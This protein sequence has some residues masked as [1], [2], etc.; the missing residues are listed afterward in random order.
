MEE[1]QPGQQT[2]SLT[3][4]STH[5]HKHSACRIVIL[6]QIVG[7]K[8]NDETKLTA[9]DCQGIH[10][11]LCCPFWPVCQPSGPEYPEGMNAESML[12]D[13]S[14]RWFSRC[15]LHSAEYRMLALWDLL[16][17]AG[18]RLRH[19]ETWICKTW[20]SCMNMPHFLCIYI[21]TLWRRLAHW[22]PMSASV[23]ARSEAI[24]A[25]DSVFS[26]WSSAIVFPFFSPL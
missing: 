12:K 17:S 15:L 24:Q 2:E 4:W 14:I 21:D 1:L 10:T 26:K 3:F 18:V 25:R 16:M 11:L 7:T 20:F 6:I 8:I 9:F 22:R 5:W 13:F 19:L 23:P